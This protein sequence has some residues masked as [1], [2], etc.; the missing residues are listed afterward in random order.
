VAFEALLT[1]HVPVVT[2]DAV[3]L[4]LAL[5]PGVV[6]AAVVGAVVALAGAAAPPHAAS[7]TATVASGATKRRRDA[8]IIGS[9]TLCSFDLTRR[10]V[11]SR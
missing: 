4:G 5:G 8:E 7:R 2:V 11:V 3:A 10:E 9:S 6:A 1:V